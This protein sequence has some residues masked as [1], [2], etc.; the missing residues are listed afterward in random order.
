[1]KATRHRGG[2]DVEFIP[3]TGCDSLA[4]AV[5]IMKRGSYCSEEVIHLMDFLSGKFRENQQ[6]LNEELARRNVAFPGTL[7]R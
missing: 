1:M 6:A 2:A 4:S 7:E 5:L 3:V